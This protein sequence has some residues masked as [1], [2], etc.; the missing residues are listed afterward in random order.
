MRMASHKQGLNSHQAELMRKSSI[1][2]QQILENMDDLND[3]II[4]TYNPDAV[5]EK[6]AEVAVIPV[7][8]MVN[9]STSVATIPLPTPEQKVMNDI[10]DELAKEVAVA[11]AKL[12]SLREAAAVE[13]ESK[14][15]EE[16]E[17]LSPA[18]QQKSA[19][20]NLL[21]SLPNAPS[22]AQIEGLKS[23]YGKNGI[24]VL[25]LGEDDVYLFTYL[26]R[27]QWQQIQKVVQAAASSD[28]N[29]NP[30][31]MLK[32]KVIQYTVLW[33]KGVASPEFLYNSRA[34]VIDTLYQS[35]LLNSYFLQPQQAMMLTTQL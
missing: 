27:G 13:A 4:E 21:K 33:P 8:Q 12:A 6:V 30:D 19:I 26:R 35:I 22:E 29:Q 17:E 24:H 18:D 15:E 16:E 5:V 32:E 9:N 11:E 20:L 2:P 25:A 23:K 14:T 7:P 28:V 10:E 34:G 31:E 1:S 3:E